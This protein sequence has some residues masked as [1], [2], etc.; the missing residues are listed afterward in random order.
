MNELTLKLGDCLEVMKEIPDGAV[1]LILCDLPYGTMK[2]AGLDGWTSETMEW[3]ERLDFNSLFQEYERILR[4]N[5]SIILFSQEPYTSELR[6][7]KA[8]NIEFA[9]PMIW[10]KTILQMR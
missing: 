4:R 1:D 8:T 7:S 6:F 10:E 9:Y 2:G 3:D 5:G